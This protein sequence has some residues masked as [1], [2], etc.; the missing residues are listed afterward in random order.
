MTVG[1]D[2]G[3]D[4]VVIIAIVVV[5]VLCFLGT[6]YIYMVHQKKKLISKAA[7]VKVSTVHST[8]VSV[9][10]GYDDPSMNSAATLAAAKAATAVA[11]REA[12]P[13]PRDIALRSITLQE[14]AAR[15]AASQTA[16]TCCHPSRPH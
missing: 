9:D 6:G 3:V 2:D 11:A 1:G 16:P 4:L 10:S 8:L 7:E 5:V 13:T 15:L 12:A 14:N